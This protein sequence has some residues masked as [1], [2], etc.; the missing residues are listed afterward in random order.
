MTKEVLYLYVGTNGTI[1][2]PV[3]LEDTYYMRR[4]RITS[5]QGK[6]LV[7]NGKVMGTTATIPEEELELWSET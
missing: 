1:L 4:L 2:S 5:A 7:K 3:H 6:F